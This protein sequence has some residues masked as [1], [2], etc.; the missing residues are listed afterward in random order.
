MIDSAASTSRFS[1]SLLPPIFPVLA[2]VGL[3]LALLLY[4]QT[5]RE[6][7]IDLTIGR[8]AAERRALEFL[9]AQ[10]V[11]IDQRWR[12]SSFR[13]ETI[14]QD[15]MIA[16]SG[17]AELQSLAQQDLKFAGWHVRL[18]TPLDPEE[19]SVDV[20]G[21]TGRIMSYQHVIKEEAPGA[22]ISISAAEQLA[23]E[24]LAARPGGGPA[25]GELRLLARRVTRQP[26]R[27]DQVFTW[28]RPALRR[29]DATYRYTVTVAGDQVGR[30]DE[31]SHIPE[32]WQRLARWHFRRGALLNTIG[33]TA[34]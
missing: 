23:L 28:E 3:L 19:W 13:T 1:R 15:Y 4:R 26:N 30:I 20:S 25:P 22:T 17:L 18:F 8:A 34:A 5:F 2:V 14:A 33:W 31:Y 24:A 29:G 21:R 12:S 6:A 11:A 16:S 27:T 9:A 7:T 10:G 32:S